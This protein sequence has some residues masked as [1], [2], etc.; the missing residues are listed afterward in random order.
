MTKIEPP[1]SSISADDASSSF[2]SSPITDQSLST[3]GSTPINP[4][5][6]SA[7]TSI[8]NNNHKFIEQNNEKLDNFK[9]HYQHQGSGENYQDNGNFSDYALLRKLFPHHDKTILLDALLSCDGSTVAAIQHLLTHNVGRKSNIPQRSHHGMKPDRT[10]N[11]DDSPNHG[12]SSFSKR[13]QKS[14]SPMSSP[15][16]N[17]NIQ[18][19]SASRRKSLE[20]TTPPPPPS[21]GIHGNNSNQIPDLSSPVLHHGSPTHPMSHSH[22]NPNF[23]F[24]SSKFSSY[25][26]AQAQQFYAHAHQRYLAAAAAAAASALQQGHPHGMGHQMTNSQNPLAVPTNIASIGQGGFFSGNILSRP[27]FAQYLSNAAA[28]Q[29]HI[30]STGRV[31]STNIGIGSSNS[32]HSTLVNPNL[33][34]NPSSGIPP[35]FQTSSTSGKYYKVISI[36]L[37]STYYTQALTLKYKIL[38]IKR[39]VDKRRQCCCR[40][41]SCHGCCYQ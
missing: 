6:T 21:L 22:S 5:A 24:P 9:K 41:S 1:K 10:M 28:A 4:I 16:L 25:A 26:A 15:P 3:I 36:E 11:V 34:L 39:S 14:A 23:N 2:P 20:A 30:P 27:D 7:S 40:S 32:N 37:D 13:M 17:F 33:L 19:R 18:K 12:V 29:H 35:L 8:N 38:D 31:G